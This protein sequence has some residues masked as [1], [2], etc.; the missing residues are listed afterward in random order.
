MQEV[1]VRPRRPRIVVSSLQIRSLKDCK[2]WTRTC[3]CAQVLG[4]G[5]RVS[6]HVPKAKT[7]CH[8][9]FE[10]TCYICNHLLRGLASSNIRMTD[11]GSNVQE[12]FY[13]HALVSAL[14][15]LFWSSNN[16]INLKAYFSPDFLSV[17]KMFIH[18]RRPAP[19]HC[20]PITPIIIFAH[21]CDYGHCTRRCGCAKPVLQY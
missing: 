11:I 20:N 6:G 4:T 5:I 1:A 7:I 9:I 13:K 15:M 17:R 8:C 12:N 19:Y 3:V 10:C 18:V 14:R 2:P 21:T 16:S